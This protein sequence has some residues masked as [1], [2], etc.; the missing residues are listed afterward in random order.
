MINAYDSSDGARWDQLGAEE[1]QGRF[2]RLHLVRQLSTSVFYFVDDPRLPLAQVL[3]DLRTAVGRLRATAAP[4]WLA[5]QAGP[6]R[7]STAD[8]ADLQRTSDSSRWQL[9]AAWS[10]APPGQCRS[11]ILEAGSDGD[12]VQDVELYPYLLLALRCNA[13]DHK[14][15]SRQSSGA[16][17]DPSPSGFVVSVCRHCHTVCLMSPGCSNNSCSDGAHVGSALGDYHEAS[18]HGARRR[19]APQSHPRPLPRTS[20]ASW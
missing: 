14:A 4:H 5:I 2:E 10:T 3:V 8:L 19:P 17:I 16:R 9:V 15:P 1:L 7:I 6:H 12:A 13:A 18:S 11:P 20:S